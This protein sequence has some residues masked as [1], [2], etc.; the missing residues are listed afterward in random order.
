[1]NT[2][3]QWTMAATLMLALAACGG[4]SGDGS[5]APGAD[6]TGTLKT[7][8]ASSA[9]TPTSGT[10]EAPATGNDTAAPNPPA[11]GSGSTA[12]NG[13]ASNTDDTAS[14]DVIS[15]AGVRGDV[16]IAALTQTDG[17]QDEPIALNPQTPSHLPKF[18]ATD[19]HIAFYQTATTN[20]EPGFPPY[21][22]Q[23]VPGSVQI[24]TG[25]STITPSDYKPATLSFK[26]EPVGNAA[27]DNN[28]KT[29]QFAP[30]LQMSGG[31]YHETVD[32]RL[33]GSNVPISTDEVYDMNNWVGPHW[34]ESALPTYVSISSE[35][36]D[37]EDR[38]FTLCVR[39]TN[40]QDMP[41]Q[42]LVLQYLSR[43]TCTRWG[44]PS[45]WQAGQ[46]L[47]RREIFVTDARAKEPE[48]IDPDVPY[49]YQLL[50]ATL[51]WSSQPSDP[52]R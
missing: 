39:L 42:R 38:S 48:S 33:N 27:T 12:D 24:D 46:P 50:Y 28:P 11:D 16:L 15:A 47:E 40:G 29:M 36:F 8:P 1:M 32:L 19:A 25:T 37:A 26:L 6:A 18:S 30:Y 51:R 20:P 5:G 2:T 31:V 34:S 7:E 22:H 44:V 35:A 45:D 43:Q 9:T 14:P 10:D 52:N 49:E 41:P 4:S 13:A 3:Y 21:Y 23:V 17:T